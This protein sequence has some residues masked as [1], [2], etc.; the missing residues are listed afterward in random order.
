MGGFTSDIPS[1]S[2]SQLSL[3][4][5]MCGLEKVGSCLSTAFLI[6]TAAVDSLYP[7]ILRDCSKGHTALKAASDLLSKSMLQRGKHRVSESLQ[8][9]SQ[10]KSIYRQILVVTAV[11]CKAMIIC[12][13]SLSDRFRLC[14][15]YSSKPRKDCLNG[16]H[17]QGWRKV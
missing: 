5:L 9:L 7:L 13:H 8:D 14:K 12:M 10:D 16:S 3:I 2:S 1:D 11:V 4:W 15:Q 6:G 17:G